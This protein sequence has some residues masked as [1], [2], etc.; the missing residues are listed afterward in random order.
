[1]R[2]LSLVNFQCYFGH[3]QIGEHGLMAFKWVDQ[4][5]SFWH[6]GRGPP[7]W[8]LGSSLRLE[9]N[10]PDCLRELGPADGD[11]DVELHVL[12]CRLTY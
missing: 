10:W 4:H 2:Y 8:S 9:V 3:A 6:W 7:V 11:D 12:G 5:L 1:M